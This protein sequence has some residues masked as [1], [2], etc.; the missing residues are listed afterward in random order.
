M[1]LPT[2]EDYR[3]WF[4]SIKKAVSSAAG[5]VKDAIADNAKDVIKAG[6]PWAGSAIGGFFA[7]ADRRYRFAVR[8]RFG[9]AIAA[10]SRA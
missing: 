1:S 5:K 7:V 6:L 4:S 2:E 8:Q 3:G 9:A 10:V